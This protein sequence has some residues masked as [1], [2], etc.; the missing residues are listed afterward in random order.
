[1]NEFEQLSVDSDE[2]SARKVFIADNLKII[3]PLALLVFT[4]IIILF[5]VYSSPQAKPQRGKLTPPLTVSVFDVSAQPFQINVQ[6]YGT[7]SP[8][9]QSFIVSQ[10][11]GQI[12]FVS[13]KL[14]DGGFFNKGDVLLRVDDRDYLADVKI[15]QANLADARQ[16]LAEEVALASQA[17]RDWVNLGN[18]G[19]PGDLVLRKPQQQAAQARLDA[20]QAALTKT[21]LTLERTTIIAPYDGRVLDKQVDLGQVINANTQIAEIYASDYLE[22]RLP[23]LTADLKFVNL[24]EEYRNAGATKN[25]SPV[26]IYS[27]LVEGSEP[28]LGRMV[29]T[30]SAIDENA[31]Q[32]HVVIQIDDPFNSD[33]PIKTPLRIGEYV[34]AKITGK[35][36]EDAIVIPS[37]SIYQNSYVY[38]VNDNI[39]LR[40]DIK[41][42]WQNNGQSLIGSGLNHGDLLVTTTLGQVA[43][44]LKVQIEGET[45]AKTKAKPAKKSKPEAVPTP[46]SEG[47]GPKQADEQANVFKSPRLVS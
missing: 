17:A 13:N 46:N 41:T 9:T 43:S 27:S 22:V 18:S 28:W 24:P 16:S 10:V 35:V 33:P 39:I 12:T 44:G 40:R 31:R 8:R 29:R 30:E 42:L 47:P 11:N 7:V 4:A 15:S 6:S 36:I 20:A 34:T 23:L 5:F 38:I 37:E 25:D 45:K 1:M 32:L 26:D 21:Q 19:K 3:I 14:R 2:P